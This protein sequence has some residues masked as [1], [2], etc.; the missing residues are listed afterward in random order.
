MG[1]RRYS[2]KADAATVPRGDGNTPLSEAAVAACCDRIFC[3]QAACTPGRILKPDAATTLPPAGGN[4]N[5]PAC[6]EEDYAPQN[7]FADEICVDCVSPEAKHGGAES[8]DGGFRLTPTSNP[9]GTVTI[10]LT[11][12]NPSESFQ[13]FLFKCTSGRFINLPE[14]AQYKN[15]E[16]VSMPTSSP[17]GSPYTSTCDGSLHRRA[18]VQRTTA[19]KTSVSVIWEPNACS[20][21]T[22]AATIAAAVVVSPLLWF[23]LPITRISVDIPDDSL[24]TVVTD[25]L[26]CIPGVAVCTTCIEPG[27]GLCESGDGGYSLAVDHEYYPARG[28]NNVLRLTLSG[29]S[30]VGFLLKTSVGTF[31]W[32][33]REAVFMDCSGEGGSSDRSP[34]GTGAGQAIVASR[35]RDKSELI[36]QLAVPAATASLTVTTIIQKTTEQWYGWVEPI[37]REVTAPPPP[38]GADSAALAVIVLDGTMADFEAAGGTE[39]FEERMGDLLGVPERVQVIEKRAGSVIVQFAIRIGGSKT[40][41]EAMADLEDI[42]SGGAATFNGLSAAADSLTVLS[43]GGEC[44]TATAVDIDEGCLKCK[45]AGVVALMVLAALLVPLSTVLLCAVKKLKKRKTRAQ[46]DE[47]YEKMCAGYD[48]KTK[49]KQMLP[50]ELME[51]LEAGEKVYIIDTRSKE[52]H[53]TSCVAGAQLLVPKAVGPDISWEKEPA[54]ALSPWPPP[55]GA[56][57]VCHCTAGYRSGF[58]A[59]K[60]EKQLECNVWNLHGG[61]IQWANDGGKIVKPDGTPARQVNTFNDKWAPFV[62]QGDE[63]RVWFEGYKTEDL[64]IRAKSMLKLFLA[65]LLLMCVVLLFTLV[66]IPKVYTAFIEAIQDMGAWGP[67]VAGFAWIPVCLFFVPGMILS[68]STGFAFDFLPAWSCTLIGATVGSTCAALAGRY[69]AREAVEEMLLGWPKFRAVDSAIKNDGFKVVFLL[70]L[71]PVLPFNVMNYALGTTGVPISEYF[72][73][74]LI[75]M[76]PGT[77]MFIYIGSTLRNLADALRGDLSGGDEEADSS[78]GTIRTIA[79][80][81]G[82]AATIVVTIFITITAK[83]HL[84]HFVEEEGDEEAA[85]TGFDAAL[86]RNENMPAPKQFEPLPR[87]KINAGCV[88]GWMTLALALGL[89]VFGVLYKERADFVPVELADNDVFMTAEDVKV[90]VDARTATI[91]DARN[92]FDAHLPGAQHAAWQDFSHAGGAG[93]ATHSV[94]KP[95]AELEALLSARGVSN[96][97]P[98]IVYGDWI[99]QWG[100][101]GRLLWMLDYLGHPDVKVMYGGIDAYR[102]PAPNGAG[103]EDTLVSDSDAPLAGAF[104]SPGLQEQVRAD[105]DEIAA[106]LELGLCNYAFF[107]TR[108]QAEYDGS[109]SM[110]NARREGHIPNALWYPWKQVFVSDNDGNLRSRDAIRAEL[111]SMGVTDNSIIV[112]YCTGGIRSVR[113]LTRPLLCCSLLCRPWCMP[114]AEARTHRL[115]CNCGLNRGWRRLLCCLNMRD[116][117]ARVSCTWSSNG[118]ATKARKTTM[119][120]GG[121]GRWGSPTTA[122][123]WRWGLEKENARRRQRRVK[124]RMQ[125][126][127]R[128]QLVLGMESLPPV[129]FASS[130]GDEPSRCFRRILLVPNMRNR[131]GS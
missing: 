3:T 38:A 59:A 116:D 27:A 100:E 121:N 83:K 29:P 101:E 82:L 21:R 1:A 41:A 103:Y 76:A 40:P 2:L 104:V 7:C 70:R 28:V 99:N 105:R 108:T 88:V 24:Q 56:T 22:G 48:S 35:S 79:L 119:A 129:C 86:A 130:P 50:K 18:V 113:A 62:H 69:L 37:V 51:K 12:S 34:G 118:V 94:L 10:T 97:R 87:W 54:D 117:F 33:P 126:F 45:S 66:D 73:A 125:C 32:L 49:S 89:L 26:Y 9:D 25:A 6:C 84:D 47:E 120:L 112:S 127:C 46:L 58:A 43:T 16:G 111:A 31:E 92:D 122:C 53:L 44:A 71:S 98:V 107:D 5:D 96:S 55:P 68:L 72:F 110:Y 14:A 93:E 39:E 67:I 17:G 11:N 131:S 80:I 77:A 65:M 61:I 60:L 124:Q 15:C 23:P 106:A 81:V 30:F 57:V 128:R 115:A 90:H 64:E 85:K 95:K 78:S 13:G 75:G 8:G 63:L 109:R 52:E 36:V 20:E 91:L 74:S 114:R 19:S 102:L 123:R 42:V 4:V